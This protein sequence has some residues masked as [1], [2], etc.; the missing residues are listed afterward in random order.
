MNDTVVATVAPRQVRVD[1]AW[2]L[3]GVAVVAWIVSGRAG[4]IL[5]FED[6]VVGGTWLALGLIAAVEPTPR[7]GPGL[8]AGAACGSTSAKVMVDQG[9]GDGSGRSGRSVLS[10]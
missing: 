3:R 4:L 8:P 2:I 9:T 1:T 5:M 10:H 6:R 7:A